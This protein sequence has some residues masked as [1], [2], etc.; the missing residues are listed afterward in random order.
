ML[1]LKLKKRPAT[2]PKK[3]IS[4]KMKSMLVKVNWKKDVV[5]K[6][7]PFLPISGCMGDNLLKAEDSLQAS[8]TCLGRQVL[9]LRPAVKRSWSRLAAIGVDTAS[10]LALARRHA[11]L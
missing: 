9:R 7:V 4:N 6:N 2:P 11:D 1:N 3:G 5:D 10:C 8:S